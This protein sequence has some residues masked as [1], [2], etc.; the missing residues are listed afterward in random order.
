MLNFVLTTAALV[1]TAPGT[2]PEPSATTPA[3]ASSAQPWGIEID[4]IQPF[5]PEVHIIRPKLT[6]TTWGTPEGLR[7]DLV[8]GLYIRPNVAHDILE[9]INEYMLTAGYRQYLWRG[10]HV[11]TLLNGGVAWGT[12]QFDG[13]D[14]TTAS[15]FLDVNVGYRFSFFSPGGFFYTGDE[16][17]GFYVAVQGGVLLSL[18]VA[19]IGPRDG[20]PDNFPQGMLLVGASF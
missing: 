17:V 10:L 12:N 18:G 20:K 4:L 13:L 9:R 7:G 1:L 14:Y 6:W 16:T 19:D 3:S 2:P 8:L 15:L 5:V 11:E